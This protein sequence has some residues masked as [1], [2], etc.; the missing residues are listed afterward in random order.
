MAKTNNIDLN[1]P[2]VIAEFKKIQQHNLD[3]IQAMKEGRQPPTVEE[4]MA[5]DKK[6]RDKDFE[7]KMEEFKIK[8]KENKLKFNEYLEKT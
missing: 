2:Q 6:K 5:E 1:D 3:D 8:E 7:I 4:R